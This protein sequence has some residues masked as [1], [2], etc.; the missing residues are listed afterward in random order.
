MGWQ[1]LPAVVVVVVCVN[2]FL[3]RPQVSRDGDRGAVRLRGIAAVRF[4]VQDIE[5]VED[6]GRTSLAAGWGM[7]GWRGR[8]TMN[9]RLSP[10]TRITFE[11]A[12]KG[13]VFGFPVK[14]RVLDAAPLT[15]SDVKR[16]LRMEA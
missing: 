11:P 4:G 8:W 13:R 1:A 9:A 14:V 6:I 5:S 3:S 7:H 10:A 15:A 2:L 12:A 16:N